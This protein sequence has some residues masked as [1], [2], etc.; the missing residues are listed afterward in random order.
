[1]EIKKNPIP[2]PVQKAFQDGEIAGTLRHLSDESFLIDF[3]SNDYIG[4]AKNVAVRTK[5]H[6]LLEEYPLQ[7]GS[8]GS[9]LLSGNYPLIRKTEGYLTAFHG[10]EKG[11]LFNSG[12]DA[13]LGIFSSIPQKGDVVLYDQYIHASIRDG[14][15][16]NKAQNFKFKHNSLADL[17]EK[18]KR[19]APFATTLYIATEAVFSMD[20]DTPDL[21]AMV[22][23]AKQYNAYII[24][25]E[26]HSV[27]IFGN[28]GEGL[29]QA[30]GIEKD[31]FLRLITFG[32]GIGAHGA[33]VVA[34]TEVIDYLVNFARSFIYTTAA[35]PESI[36]TLLTSYMLLP[37]LKERD[38]LHENIV[39]FREKAQT[40]AK[41]KGI[42]FID[43]SSAIQGL[44]IPDSQ[45]VKQV[46]ARLQAQ[47][48]GIKP[49]LSPT[50]PK[51]EERLR[52]C[53]HSYNTKEEINLL[54]Q[55]ISE[56]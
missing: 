56:E 20:G 12:Y 39:F 36:A 47:G 22:A 29:C 10:A 42:T 26:A 5:A 16:L 17:E 1:M 48:M 13:N 8:T 30:L 37:E 43:S 32:K 33:L 52:I 4:L 53:L 25:D 38:L 31:I 9:R 14:L 21:P 3:Y 19:F 40:L 46:A 34:Q 50:V 7:N 15:Q 24:I 44:I 35:A 2:K 54:F 27:G 51:G 41:E 6:S 23:L 55:T 28:K 45:K 11:L 18:L 49:I